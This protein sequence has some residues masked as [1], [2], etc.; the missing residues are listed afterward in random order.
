MPKRKASGSQKGG[1]RK[2]QRTTGPRKV[3]IKRMINSAL[4]RAIENKRGA[5]EVQSLV[6]GTYTATPVSQVS[7]LVPTLSKGTE[8]Y[9]RVGSQVTLKRAVLRGYIRPKL[10]NAT[11]GFYTTAEKL[12]NLRMIIGKPRNFNAVSVQGR[13][14][15]INI[16]DLNNLLRDGIDNK[17]FASNNPLSLIR[18]I[19]KTYWKIAHDK[20]YRI[21]ISSNGSATVQGLKADNNNYP[22]NRFFTIDLTKHF[23][24]K[25]IYDESS[26]YPQN[27]SLYMIFNLCDIAG[28]GTGDTNCVDVTW[29]LDYEYEDA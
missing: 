19:A 5:G 22:V 28:L 6:L 13:A 2:R 24:K 10:A 3:T 16:G 20:I 21:G 14:G 15:D 12:W 25:L 9:Q 29:Y 1:P 4:G 7:V 17:P 18:P 27:D 8:E 26:S 11:D 23:K